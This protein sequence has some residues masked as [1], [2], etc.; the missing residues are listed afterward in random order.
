MFTVEPLGEQTGWTDEVDGGKT[1]H[2]L[3]LV[4]EQVE[5]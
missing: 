2:L 4:P 5:Q 3:Y 1:L